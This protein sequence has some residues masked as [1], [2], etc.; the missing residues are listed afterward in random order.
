MRKLIL[1]V[2]NDQLVLTFEEIE[3]IDLINSLVYQINKIYIGFLKTK[4]YDEKDARLIV[5]DVRKGSVVVVLTVAKSLLKTLPEFVDFFSRL[6]A[7]LRGSRDSELEKSL[8]MSLKEFLFQF[9]YNLSIESISLF[10]G[11]DIAMVLDAKTLWDLIRKC[12][13]EYNGDLKSR[14]AEVL[15]KK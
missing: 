5:R 4:G 15:R 8:K 9:A 7:Y 3:D 10:L 2:E 14:I 13:K 1:N 12:K 6:M 11:G